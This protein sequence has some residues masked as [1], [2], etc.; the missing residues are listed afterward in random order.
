MAVKRLPDG[1]FACERMKRIARSGKFF[2]VF[3]EIGARGVM[4]RGSFGR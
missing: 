2:R 3:P 4:G 1:V